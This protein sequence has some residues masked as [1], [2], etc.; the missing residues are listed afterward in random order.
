MSLWFTKV[1]VLFAW[2]S[3]STSRTRF[4]SSARPADRLIAV[5]VLP[6]PP[7]WLAIAMTIRPPLGGPDAPHGDF[8]PP[9]FDAVGWYGRVCRPHGREPGR[10]RAPLARSHL[11]V[12]AHVVV[13]EVVRPF[14]LLFLFFDVA[15]FEPLDVVVDVIVVVR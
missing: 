14:R 7:F 3:R 5:V 15:V 9:P 12:A 2:G 13:V 11:V 10:G 6:T 4:P 1:S 8:A